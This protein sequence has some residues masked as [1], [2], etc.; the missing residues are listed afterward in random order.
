MIS[1]P[2]NPAALPV[3]GTVPDLAAGKPQDQA[4]LLAEKIDALL[5]Q[6]QCQ[7]CGYAACKPYAE[8]IARNEADI[9]Q[10]PPGG[11]AG[12]YRLATLL[13]REFKPLSPAHGAEMP[14]QVAIIDES[15]CIGCTLCIQACPVD[16]IV[17]ANKLMHTV[18][19]EQC[20]GCE[21]C[22]EPCPVDCIALVRPAEQNEARSVFDCFD[23]N[24]EEKQ[25]ADA[26]RKRYEFHLL[27]LGREQ[28]ERADRLAA[29]VARQPVADDTADPKRA[30]IAAALERVRAQQAQTQAET[31]KQ[32]ES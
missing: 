18:V 19:T 4:E 31:K 10:C 26:A 22:I 3:S 20:T 16:A 9:N 8:A 25:A 2:D 21:L 29:M 7:R 14:K 6:T 5:P 30:L 32:P 17:G 12:I 13:D 11:T 27:R 15:L 1:H 24:A 23:M 28:R